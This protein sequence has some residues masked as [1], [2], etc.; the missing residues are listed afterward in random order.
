M[1]PA[2]PTGGFL[3]GALRIVGRAVR[4][5]CPNCGG[6]GLFRSWFRMARECP[7][8]HLPLERN[9]QGYQVGAYMFNIALAELVFIVVLVGVLVRTWPDP[10]W[11][12]L[13]WISVGLMVI[14]PVVFYPFSKTLFL[15]FHLLFHPE[16][17]AGPPPPPPMCPN[18]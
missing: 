13:T 14:L 7:V 2:H 16:R 15:G 18:A 6:R 11:K 1:Q 3:R 5:R 17:E 9:E 8:C 12:A 10:P 4:L